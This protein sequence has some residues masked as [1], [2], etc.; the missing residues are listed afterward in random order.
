MSKMLVQVYAGKRKK[1]TQNKNK[2]EITAPTLLLLKY[3]YL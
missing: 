3:L 1:K 2:T